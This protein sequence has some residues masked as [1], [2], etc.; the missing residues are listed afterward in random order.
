MKG[1]T[2]STI[3]HDITFQNFKDAITEPY[4]NVFYKKMYLLN[5]EKHEMFV[6]EMNKKAISPF[7]DKRWINNNGI[8]T[9]P[10]GY[11]KLVFL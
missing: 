4:E 6:T 3:K 7:D 2:K 5:S 10:H 1:I 9:Y 8:D 11:D